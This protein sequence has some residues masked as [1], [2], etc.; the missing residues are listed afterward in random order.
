MS[1]ELLVPLVLGVAA[2]LQATCNREIAVHTGLPAAAA[3]NMLVATLAA[4]A[5][6]AYCAIRQAPDGL[7]RW[8]PD[9]TAFRWWWLLPGLVGFLI[10]LGLPWAVQRLGALSTFV[11]LVGAQVLA[12]ALWDRLHAGI[13]FSL[14]RVAG[15]VCTVIGITLLSWKPGV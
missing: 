2:V 11:V 3:L 1:T 4:L 12:S 10:V 9:V 7:L 6:A 5:F 13:P 15:A 14:P 8:P